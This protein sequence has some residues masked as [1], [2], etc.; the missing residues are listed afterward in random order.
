MGD[1]MI[2]KLGN[3]PP[4]KEIIIKFTIYQELEIAF[5]KFWEFRQFSTLTPRYFGK[6]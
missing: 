4:K 1:I 3:I 2:V 6:K 5:N